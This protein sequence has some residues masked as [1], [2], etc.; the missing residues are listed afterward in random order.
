MTDTDTRIAELLE[1]AESEGRELPLRPETI[2]ALEDAGAVVDLDT[3]AVLPG[4][5]DRPYVWN[6]TP[7]GEAFAHLV[8]AGLV[9]V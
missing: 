4:E 7:A 2:I 3:G 9:E 5:A 6:W 1:W 8:E